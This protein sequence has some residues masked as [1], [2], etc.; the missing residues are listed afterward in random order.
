MTA[1]N[2]FSAELPVGDVRA[3][4]P[5]IEP[6]ANPNRPSDPPEPMFSDAHLTALLRI[7]GGNVRLAAADA[8]EALGTS[9]AL[10]L[11]VIT[12]EDLATNGAALMGRYLERARQ[13]R[14]AAA[15]ASRDDEWGDIQFIPFQV[16]PV[17]AEWR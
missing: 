15:A 8:C 2:A 17:H 1:F 13:M 5:D 14:Q 9:E 3:L 11:K 4:I 7:N 6:L 16:E 10:I 12:T